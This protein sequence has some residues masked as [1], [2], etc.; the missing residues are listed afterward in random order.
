MR[1]M[2]PILKNVISLSSGE[3][4]AKALGFITTMYLARMLGS[5]GFG[6]IGF[7][8]AILAY[9]TLL[10]NP[11]LDTIGIRSIAAE[12]EHAPRTVSAVLTARTILL[13][14]AMLLFLVILLVSSF[15]TDVRKVYLGYG[16][17]LLL[18]PLTFDFYFVG[19]E[20]MGIV[21]A[22]K[23]VQATLYLAA[24][25]LLVSGPSDLA[26]VPLLLVLAS[27]CSLLLQPF[28]LRKPILHFDRDTLRAIPDVLRA[29]LLVGGAQLLILLYLQIDLVMCGYLLDAEQVGFYTAAQRIVAAVT[30]LPL[31]LL[32]AWMPELARAADGQ[33]R[34]D[35]LRRFFRVM[36]LPGIVISTAGMLFAPAI[37][38]I[39]FGNVYLEGS[40]AL[41]ILFLSVGFVFV[42][43]ALANPLLA[44]KRDREYLIIVLGGAMLNLALNAMLIPAAG[45]TGAA[46]ATASAEALVLLL[47]VR[48]QIRHL[49]QQ[50]HM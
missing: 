11:G 33:Q 22:R 49:R 43:M 47:A 37:L 18:L 12:P 10:V 17:L 29:A 16:L 50:S 28:F 2:H 19:T 35:A 9:L 5:E 6:T 41:R 44:W 8:T 13:L 38:Q 26:L 30:L 4:V 32:Q 34:R 3:F 46:W 27:L 21:A 14:P 7:A 24:V 25:V 31:V 15:P 1:T 40:T 23:T 20:R 36:V 48:V 39:V 42:N 45:I